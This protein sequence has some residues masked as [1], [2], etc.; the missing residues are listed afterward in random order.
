MYVYICIL[1]RV[2]VDHLRFT[3]P[4]RHRIYIYIYI[5]IYIHMH[6]EPCCR[7]PPPLYET[8]QAS[9]IY[10]CIDVCMYVCIYVCVC[11]YIY[12]YTYAF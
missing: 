2:A 9:I 11:M 4:A 8:C 1:N 6:F 7:R 3:E 5:Y 12:I 10:V